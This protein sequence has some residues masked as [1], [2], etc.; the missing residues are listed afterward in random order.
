MDEHAQA[1][2]HD[3][4]PLSGYG[5]ARCTDCLAC[6]EACPFREAMDLAPADIVRRVAD[7]STSEAVASQAIWLCTDCRA[8]TKACEQGIDVAG[9]FEALR[10]EAF[11]RTVRGDERIAALHERVTRAA[12][13]DGR[14]REGRLFLAMTRRHRAPFP[15]GALA[16]ALFIK[17]KFGRILSSRGAGRREDRS[18]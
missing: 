10:R 2:V 18:P 12:V 4:D 11:T 17:G 13:R 16:L 7:G 3:S 1:R 6:S 9:L 14:L 15:R 5:L 8:C